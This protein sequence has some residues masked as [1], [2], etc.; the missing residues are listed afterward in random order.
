MPIFNLIIVVETLCRVVI[1]LGVVDVS[2][3]CSPR[4]LGLYLL[5]RELTNIFQHL[6][7]AR[8]YE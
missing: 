3:V 6:P 1:S 2:G 7:G 5:L 8:D 4:L